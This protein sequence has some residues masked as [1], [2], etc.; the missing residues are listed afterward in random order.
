M[1][2]DRFYYVNFTGGHEPDLPLQSA[3]GLWE[4]GYKDGTFSASAQM[5]DENTER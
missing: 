3:S 2:C 4:E 5:E 1:P